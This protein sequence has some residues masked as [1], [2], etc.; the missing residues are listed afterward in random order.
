MPLLTLPK[1]R[2]PRLRGWPFVIVLGLVLAIIAIIDR[3]TGDQSTAS[4]PAGCELR[5]A[6]AT[7]NVRTGPSAQA[8]QAQTLTEGTDVAGTRVLTDGF[9]QL[10]DG[11][12][13]F[14]QYVTPT[15]GSVCS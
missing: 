1:L 14:D 9:R 3:G 12:W 8:P 7:L 15:A 13:V 10:Q 4:G 2:V 6:V 5:V 11:N